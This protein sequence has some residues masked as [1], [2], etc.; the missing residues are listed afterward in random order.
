MTKG[1]EVVGNGKEKEKSSPAGVSPARALSRK[2]HALLTPRQR[3]LVVYSQNAGAGGARGRWDQWDFQEDCRAACRV[4]TRP[5]GE[6]GTYRL[7]RDRLCDG[8]REV[9]TLLAV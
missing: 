3:T 5:Q 7:E 8:G 4:E 6:K 2:V 1:A 9:A